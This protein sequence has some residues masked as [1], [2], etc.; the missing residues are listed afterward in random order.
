[1]AQHLYTHT[2]PVNEKHLEQAVSILEKGGVI[3]YPT[4]VNWAVGCD[5]SHAKALKRILQLKPQHPKQQPFSLLCES[6]SM[7]SQVASLSSTAY[8]DLKKILP[9]AYT[10][11]LKSNETFLRKIKDKRQVV[12]VRVPQSPLLLALINYYKKPLATSSLG[13][14]EHLS[15]GYQ[16]E[17]Q[18]GHGIDLLLDLGEEVIPQETSIL[19]L[20]GDELV[21]IRKGVGSV[22]SFE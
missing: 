10:V 21:V 22:S 11:L 6:L 3:A 4:D 1:M 13:V 19:D 15:F 16:I 5:P 7:V 2:D 17:E 12:G 8:K 18:Y 9:G 20:T 14:E